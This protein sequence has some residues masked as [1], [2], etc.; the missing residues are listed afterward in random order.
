MSKVFDLN[1]QVAFSVKVNGKPYEI[2]D[3]SYEEYKEKVAPLLAI[4]G[5]SMDE[6]VRDMEAVI[7]AY[8]PDLDV[9]GLGS[10]KLAALYSHVLGV[11]AG[12]A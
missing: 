12:E 5:K 3:L 7:K 10:R 9:K 8:I 2:L 1:E 4:E 11:T 6:V